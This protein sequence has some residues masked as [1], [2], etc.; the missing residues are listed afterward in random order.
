MLDLLWSTAGCTIVELFL[1]IY[2]WQ[3][4]SIF[5]VL[6]CSH[7]DLLCHLIDNILQTLVCLFTNISR[8]AKL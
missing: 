8:Y 3:S 5:H 2:S 1:Y 7:S 6:H 4:K